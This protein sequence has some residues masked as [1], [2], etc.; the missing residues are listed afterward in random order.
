M[1]P[2]PALAEPSMADTSPLV[3]KVPRYREPEMVSVPEAVL[4]LLVPETVSLLKSAHS[5]F[6]VCE[7]TCLIFFYYL[8]SSFSNPK[9]WL[10]PLKT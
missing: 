2:L 9:S 7:L 4:L 10:L 8:I 1:A 6:A 3:G 5:P